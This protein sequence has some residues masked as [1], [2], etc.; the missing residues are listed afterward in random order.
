MSDKGFLQMEDAIQ[1]SLQVD[2][3]K[4]TEEDFLNIENAINALT[5]CA[6]A[7]I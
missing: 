4:I 2:F 5:V 3:E 7:R 1:N 6:F